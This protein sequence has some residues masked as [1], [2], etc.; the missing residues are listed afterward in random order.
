MT[1]NDRYPANL[2][3]TL[4]GNVS[5][6]V[7]PGSMFILI[8]IWWLYNVVR[9]IVLD[10]NMADK[11]SYS[12]R[13]W[14][15]APRSLNRCRFPPCSSSIPLE[16]TVI[17]FLGLLGTLIELTGAHWKLFAN[18]DFKDDSMNN[19][20]HATM[21]AFFILSGIVNILVHRDAIKGKSLSRLSHV[22][23]AFA[24]FIEGFLF[25]FHLEGRS[26]LDSHAHSLIYSLC[27]VISF[28]II[29]ESCNSSPIL[30][31]ARCFCTIVQGTW[32]YQVAF[33][34]HGPNPWS[35]KSK[36]ATMFVPIAF[37]W[38]CLAVLVGIII[39]VVMGQ[40]TKPPTCSFDDVQQEMQ[41]LLVDG[42][43]E[44]EQTTCS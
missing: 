40:R 41:C 24:F 16:P 42:N 17:I 22:M 2:D 30:G 44:G 9:W 21:Y 18:G 35:P 36:P 34:L 39:C 20:S 43:L 31:L 10:G 28:I 11:L 27:F 37:A 15:D 38:H 14:Y 8:G 3:D 23:L 26:G 25:Y 33:M 12:S 1:G 5:G 4:F 7:A 29:L 19:F 13:V 32:F 6:H